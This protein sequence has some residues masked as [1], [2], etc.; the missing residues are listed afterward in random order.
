[1]SK[2]NV[3]EN[4]SDRKI[5]IM[6]ATMIFCSVVYGFGMFK[7]IPMQDAITSHFGVNEG[8][9]GYLNSATNWVVIILSV[10][11][12]FLIRKWPSKQSIILG[13]AV[14]LA[15]MGMQLLAPKFP[16]FVAGRAIEGG[17]LGLATL[18]VTSLL[19]NMVPRDKV[20]IWSS[21]SI[22]CAVA[23][24]ILITKGGS[25][26]MLK[27]GMSFLQIFAGIAMMYALAIVVCMINIP[28]SVK[29]NGVAADAKPTREQTL[30]VFKNKSNWL[31][32]IAYI[33]FSLVSVSFSA[34]VVKYMIIK[35]LEPGQAASVYS[36]TTLIGMA[37]MFVFGWISDKLGTKRKIVMAGFFA[38]A[39][40]LIC[41]VNLP[42]SMI[43]VYVIV[44][45]TL[46]RS[47]AGLSTAS[48]TDIAEVPSDVPVVNSLKNEVTQV[49]TVV[50]TIVLGYIIQCLGYEI[51]IYLL[52]GTMVLGGICWFF[53]KR[54]P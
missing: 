50:F 52:A 4:Y 10:Q 17:G 5:K 2:E 9:Y 35:G 1:M 40:A 12:G 51:A 21:V 41:L 11:M 42:A 31:V 34:Y 24:Q 13:F 6:L 53:A 15:G 20:G 48:A 25:V 8:A 30:R 3:R 23:P 47:I 22:L 43:M 14:A 37:S 46:P 28:A 18:A 7:F 36:Y 38:G 27:A 39:V 49:G 44:Y 29:A 45:G 32:N 54:I 16:L 19:L 33:F 26:L